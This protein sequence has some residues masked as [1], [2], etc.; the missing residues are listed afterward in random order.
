VSFT[1]YQDMHVA[2][3]GTCI[4]ERNFKYYYILCIVLETLA[5][6]VTIIN[7][8]IMAGTTNDL[9]FGFGSRKFL[10]TQYS[11]F[12]NTG[13]KEAQVQGSSFWDRSTIVSTISLTYATVIFL[14]PHTGLIMLIYR[15]YLIFK[16]RTAREEYRVCIDKH[17]TS[18]SILRFDVIS[19]RYSILCPNR[20]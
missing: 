13:A 18:A 10:L 2:F 16:D 12:E 20:L 8:I 1:G 15:T 19:V 9:I 7:S 6:Y 17:I 14:L 11:F 5:T 3:L 4:G